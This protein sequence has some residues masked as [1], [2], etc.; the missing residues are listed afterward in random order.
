MQTK[1][2]S[3]S[4]TTIVLLIATLTSGVMV[5]QRRVGQA[6]GTVHRRLARRLNLVAASPLLPHRSMAAMNGG[7]GL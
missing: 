2:N 1:L 7:D 3:L 6:P 4:R 5:S